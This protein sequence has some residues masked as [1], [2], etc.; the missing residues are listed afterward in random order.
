MQTYGPPE[1]ITV[2]EVVANARSVLPCSENLADTRCTSFCLQGCYMIQ[3]GL[4][5]EERAVLQERVATLKA[6]NVFQDAY[7]IL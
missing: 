6:E 2:T 5:R 1:R 7:L 3:F 4:Q